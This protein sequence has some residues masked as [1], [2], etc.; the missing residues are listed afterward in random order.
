MQE[1]WVRSLIMEDPTCHIGLRATVIEPGWDHNYWAHEPQQRKPRHL[2]YWGPCTAEPHAP[3]QEKP[4]QWETLARLLE[5]SPCSLQ[6]KTSRCSNED[7]EQ[8][9]INKIIKNFFLSVT[10]WGPTDWHRQVIQKTL[11]IIL[12]IIDFKCRYWRNGSFVFHFVKTFLTSTK[13]NE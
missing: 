13:I 6:L 9:K 1:T 5:S 12:R 3:Q 7:P 4:L 8:S 2:S 10:R 11:Q